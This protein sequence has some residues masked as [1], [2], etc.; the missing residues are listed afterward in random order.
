M[1]ER[2][3]TRALPLANRAFDY[4][5]LAP[6]CCNACRVC[7]ANGVVGLIFAGAGAVSVSVARL[8]KRLA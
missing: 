8:A 6:A 2:T 4:A 1:L 5:P 3:M 7:A